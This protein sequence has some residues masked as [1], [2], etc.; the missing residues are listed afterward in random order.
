MDNG[1]ASVELRSDDRMFRPGGAA[2]LAAALEPSAGGEVEAALVTTHR[3]VGE[4]I[5]RY[6]RQQA[7]ASALIEHHDSDVSLW[8]FFARFLRQA[9]HRPAMAHRANCLWMSGSLTG[10]AVGRLQ[11]GM[12][13]G[14][15]R[16][17]ILAGSDSADSPDV[18]ERLADLEKRGAKV[19]VH[20]AHLP[21]MLILDRAAVVLPVREPATRP[22]DTALTLIRMPEIVTAMNNTV[23]AVWRSCAV[24]LSVYQQRML[25]SSGLI[26]RVLILL[27]MGYKDET[28]ARMLGLS[29]RT[30]R[31]HVA[32]LMAR[33]NVTSRFQAGVRASLLFSEPLDDER[34]VVDIRCHAA[35]R[36]GGL[37]PS[38]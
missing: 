31:R 6:R 33:L 34:P 29:V 5:T 9:S 1:S 4:A 12:L 11:E 24:E 2:A 21:D 22:G 13:A 30:Y 36:Y 8:P 3:L 17:L 19:R 14:G 18:A 38:G 15:G 25:I 20:R 23:A 28:A 26:G 16:L 37:E 32:T 7:Q 35:R 27:Q 10:S